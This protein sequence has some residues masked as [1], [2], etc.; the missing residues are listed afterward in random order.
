[1]TNTK[2][3]P[4]LELTDLS[5]RARRGELSAEDQHSLESALAVN[6]LLRLVHGAGRDCDE[7]TGVRP[8]DDEL[9]QRA[10]TRVLAPRRV[11]VPKRLLPAIVVAAS[12]GAGAAALALSGGGWF[13]SSESAPAPSARPSAAARNP[14][15]TAVTAA[16]PRPTSAAEPHEPQLG[17]EARS[18]EA[19]NGA[20]T[21]GEG[22]GRKLPIARSAENP[23]P[24]AATPSAAELFSAANSARKS[25]DLSRAISGYEDLQRR[26]PQSREASVSHV[27]LGKLLIASGRAREA[28]QQFRAYLDAGDGALNEEA[29]LGRAD[30]LALLGKAQEEKRVWQRLLERYPASVYAE[31]ARKRLE[32]LADELR[33]AP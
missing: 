32:A 29:L 33:T 18:G 7:I 8:G 20:P 31:R 9:I 22:P 1:M 6:P 4:L 17:V 19:A 13:H 30:S 28:E 10:V 5:T 24:A 2:Q 27:S 3:D 11:P 12:L 23:L 16:G 21:T 15:S 14:K 25:G 26:Y